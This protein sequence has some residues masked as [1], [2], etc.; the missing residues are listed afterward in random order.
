ME[1]RVVTH[2][3]MVI[4][5]DKDEEIEV[6][7]V[8]MF[9]CVNYVDKKTTKQIVIMKAFNASCA[10]SNLSASDWY[11][12]S[13]VSA[14]MTPNSANVDSATSYNGNDVLLLVMEILFLSLILVI[15]ITPNV[16]L[17]D[18][19]VVL[20]LN[21]NLLSISWLTRD[22]PVNMVFSENP[23]VVQNRLD[24]TTLARC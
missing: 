20:N 17:H 1:I 24:G 13:G 14:H 5:M 8:I 15:S 6:A 22:Y 3:D 11:L 21:R 7:N 4:P 12:N 10:L 9:L 23:F 19:L 16:K 2:Q 18:I